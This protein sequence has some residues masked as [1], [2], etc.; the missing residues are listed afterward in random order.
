MASTQS[1]TKSG[2]YLLP[3]LLVSMVLL[4]AAFIVLT[5]SAHAELRA[6]SEW[7]YRPDTE[8]PDNG[9]TAAPKN[10]LDQRAAVALE[11]PPIPMSL[12]EL[13][14]PVEVALN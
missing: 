12:T 13:L 4:V 6:S 1:W 11:C 2:A 10:D 3:I 8:A 7:P 5:A 14:R 9:T